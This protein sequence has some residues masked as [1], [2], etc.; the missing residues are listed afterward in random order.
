MVEI[1][2]DSERETEESV[3]EGGLVETVSEIS[4]AEALST[5]GGSRTGSVWE[6]R[7]S[8]MVWKFLEASRNSVEFFESISYKILLHSDS[9]SLW[10]VSKIQK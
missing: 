10:R 7:I 6:G 9:L 5:T 3:G 1:E 2:T 8:G 4:P